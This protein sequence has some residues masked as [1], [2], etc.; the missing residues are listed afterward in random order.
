MVRSSL[1]AL[2]VIVCLTLPG[3]LNP[4]SAFGQVTDESSTD[5]TAT[6][7]FG[8]ESDLSSRYV[9]RGL[10]L[11][12]A[13]VSQ[14]SVWISEGA[15]SGSIWCNYD[16]DAVGG[17]PSLN[18]LD[19]ALTWESSFGPCGIDATVQSYTYPRQQD[20][21]STVEIA[22]GMSWDLPSIQPFFTHTVDIKEYSG[23]YFGEFGLASGW[24]IN[25]RTSAEARAGLGW[26]S[27]KFNEA[28][29]GISSGALQQA[30]FEASVSF[31][32]GG[33]LHV[34][35][36][37]LFSDILD[38]DIESAIDDPTLAQVGVALGG[39]F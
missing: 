6:F 17:Q 35:P 25:E 15:F 36:H 24:E 8:F 19:V 20:Y 13:S 23:A 21:P 3:F 22:L 16:L 7:G 28:N 31:Y 26:A 37:V 29:V 10:A 2:T 4:A 18:E 14:N 33:S 39:E 12:S 38:S 34:R 5:S 1:S 9:W 27:V 30:F 11:S 32:P